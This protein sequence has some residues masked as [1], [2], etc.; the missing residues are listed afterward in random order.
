MAISPLLDRRV[1]ERAKGLCE[2]CRVPQAAYPWTFQID[3]IIAEQHHGK[4]QMMNLA[5][6]CPR[7]NRCKGPN[8]SGI[9]TQTRQLTPL[10]HPRRERWAEH[11]RWRGPRLIGLTPVGR[12][13]VQVLQINHRDDILL[14]RTLIAEGIFPPPEQ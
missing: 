2:Y 4:T 9:D 3:H 1:R 8:L 11:F 5:L 7:C 10:F 12:V 14:R 13:T 6:A